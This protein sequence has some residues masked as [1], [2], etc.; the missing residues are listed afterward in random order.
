M[1]GR[2][3]KRFGEPLLAMVGPILIAGG[4]V[5]VGLA[6]AGHGVWPALI[7]GS[8][9]LAFG[10]SLFNPSVQ[11]LISRHAGGREQGEILGAAQGM[12]SLARAVGPMLAGYLYWK[13]SSGT[14]YFVSAAICVLVAF[15]AVGMGSRLRP[16][17]LAQEPAAQAV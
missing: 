2:L 4:L 8:G 3:A 9:L 1:I 10:S 15:W 6:P 14:P 16:P 12:S 5:T 17:A 7:V 11:S 13:V